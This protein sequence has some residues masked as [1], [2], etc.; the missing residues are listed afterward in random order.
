[1]IFE[2]GGKIF[3]E[4]GKIFEEGGEIFEEGGRRKEDTLSLME[5]RCGG[6]GWQVARGLGLPEEGLLISPRRTWEGCRGSR[7]GR[8][9]YD[10]RPLPASPNL[11]FVTWL[12]MF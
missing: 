3:E 10:L 2:E 1:M 9:R 4:G 6:A 12:L 8:A 11:I 5:G 7:V